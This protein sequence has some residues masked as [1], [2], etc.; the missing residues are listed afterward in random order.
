MRIPVNLINE[1]L[2]IKLTT[3]EIVD[4][5]EKTEIEVEEIIAAKSLHKNIV[6]AKILKVDNHPNAD[7]LKLVVI[8]LKDDKTVR[9]VCG[10]PNVEPNQ[11]VAY[12]KP[13]SVLPDGSKI[14]K[15]VIRGVSSAGMLCSP[16]ELGKSDDHEG[17]AVL[18]PDLPHGISLCDIEDTQDIID[19]K[20]PANRFDMLSFVG[21]AREISANSRNNL[22]LEPKSIN[23]TFDKKEQTKIDDKQICKRFISARIKINNKV[24]SP[25]WLVDN[26]LAAGMRPINPVVDITNFVMLE[27]GQPSH[28]YDAK[29]LRSNLQV[30]FARKNEKLTTLD[31]SLLDLDKSDLLIVDNNKPIGLAGVIGGKDIETSEES[32]EIILEVANFDK[33]T[34]RRSALRH[35]IRTEASSRFEK[36][37]PLPLQEYAIKR[38][39]YLYKKI[40]KGEL[41]GEVNDQLYAW[42]WIQHIGLKIRKAEKF[43]GMKLDEKQILDGLK[44]RGFQAE[45]F[46]IV[47]EA[48]KHLGKPYLL[49]SNFKVNDIECFDC[50]YLTDYIYSLIGLRIG[51]TA[52][53]QFDNGN[54]H[55]VN[56][57]GLKAGDLLFLQ[58]DFE[59]KNL[60]KERDGIRHVGLYIGNSQ[61]VEASY[62]Q[63]KVVVTKLKQFVESGK[64]RGA[65]RYVDNFNHTLAIT[66]PWWRE[67]VRIEQDMYEEIAKIVGYSN[68]PATLPS[69]PPESYNDHQTIIRMTRLREL[70][71]DR[72][73]FE[74]MSYSFVSNK[75]LQNDSLD[76]DKHLK[77]VNPLSLEQEFL[78]TTLMSSHVQIVKNNTNYTQE[79]YGFFEISRVYEKL[80]SKSEKSEKWLL[81]ITLV[82]NEG[83]MQLKSLLD[84]LGSKY[85]WDLKYEPLQNSRYQDGISANILVGDEVIG[86][87]GQFSRDKLKKHYKNP[88]TISYCEI[89]IDR[90]DINIKDFKAKDVENYQLI[91]RD[92][93][94]E[95]DDAIWWQQIKDCIRLDDAIKKIEFVGE[96][97]NDDLKK[98]NKKRISFRLILDLGA[99]PTS[100]EISNIVNKITQNLLKNKVF[101]N[102]TII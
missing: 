90:L 101:K 14:G 82:G 28:A 48:R 99:Q 13:G 55:E 54:G 73:L 86:N 94:I 63:G 33:T 18:D 62:D 38:L 70:L 72:G 1:Y 87:Y 61:V 102:S 32:D 11:I 93:T 5:L 45:H 41:I 81:A 8:G 85:M 64:L 84:V 60:E 98:A 71:V 95:L 24:K 53:E 37:L 23:I 74:V 30:R 56:V 47:K 97:K 68:M 31:G 4:S 35:G 25:Q 75:H 27:T 43:L 17:I 100:Q 96:F 20:T 78:R 9:V 50:S 44:K 26:L 7:K 80:K 66:A 51:H 40:C 3:Q 42:P 2:K 10:A 57:E 16:R 67:D 29:K 49:G 83:Y 58:R 15:A 92:V 6:T 59:D 76:Q 69:L 91:L 12:A 88:R 34:V 65:R 77:V 36:G 21:V 89:D 19:I 39:V 79:K 22:L 46:S 52:K